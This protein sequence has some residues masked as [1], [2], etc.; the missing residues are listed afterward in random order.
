MCVYVCKR[1]AER[2]C[3]CAPEMLR[4]HMCRSV[5]LSKR[6][7]RAGSCSSWYVLPCMS[8][9]LCVCVCAACVEVCAR[10]TDVGIDN[11]SARAHTHT[12]IHIHLTQDDGSRSWFPQ[13]YAE[14]FPAFTYTLAD[15]V[16][17]RD[18]ASIS[19]STTPLQVHVRVSVYPEMC[20]HCE[21]I[22]NVTTHRANPELQ[23][24][25]PTPG[26][27]RLSHTRSALNPFR[28]AQH[29][30]GPRRPTNHC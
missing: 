2:R 7:I 15:I 29:P 13:S 6:A 26:D 17:A 23:T 18:P 8:L 30:S 27:L 21:D 22:N 10:T 9:H 19:G 5:R 28:G 4:S 11:A 1:E 12:R 24:P 25:N 20:R 16:G 14:F 3:S